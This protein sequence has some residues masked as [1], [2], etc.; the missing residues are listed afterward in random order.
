MTEHRAYQALKAARDIVIA[1]DTLAGTQVEIAR[2]AAMNDA[3]AI[4]IWMGPD[5]APTELGVES[6]YWLDSLLR[7]YFDLH[8]RAPEPPLSIIDRIFQLRAEVHT[9]LLAD[10][11]LGLSF[12]HSIRYQGAEEFTPQQIG[13][14]VG[15]LRTVWDIAYR[16]EYA[17]PAT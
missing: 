14:Q 3:A 10:W 13:D 15:A 16:M 12:V 9:A 17:N 2:T 4:D 1:A 11:T 5:V 6:T 8:V 7:V